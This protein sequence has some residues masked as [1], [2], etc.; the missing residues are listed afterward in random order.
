LEEKPNVFELRGR[1]I[2]WVDAD[3]LEMHPFILP[4]G[5]N[6]RI[7]LKDAWIVEDED[8]PI[9][10]DRILREQIAMIGDVG[11]VVK[12]VNTRHHHTFGRLE[13]R[14]DPA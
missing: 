8:D 2:D 14:V 11:N 4:A 5:F 10:H 6:L 7:R 3:T 1:I 12:I 9:E 13:A